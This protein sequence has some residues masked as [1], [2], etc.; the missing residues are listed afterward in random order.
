MNHLD[1]WLVKLATRYLASHGQ[2]T[3]PYPFVGIVLG[4]ATGT[5]REYE[6]GS[7]YAVHLPKGHV[8]VAIC[9][10]VLTKEELT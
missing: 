7:T 4:N 5:Y 9:E 3:I 10:T 6:H 2:M 8:R 1:G